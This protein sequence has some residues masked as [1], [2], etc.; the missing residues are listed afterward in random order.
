MSKPLNTKVCKY[1][2]HILGF[3]DLLL[4]FPRADISKEDER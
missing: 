2:Y 4:M 3:N 1:N